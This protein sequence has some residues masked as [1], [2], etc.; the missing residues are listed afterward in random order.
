[1]KKSKAVVAL[2]NCGGKKDIVKRMEDL[3]TFDD[4]V[5]LAEELGSYC[6]SE[7]QTKGISQ[8]QV[9]DTDEDSEPYDSE[10]MREAEGDGS[11]EGQ[12][13]KES[14]EEKEEDSNKGSASGDDEEDKKEE[15]KY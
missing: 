14:E 1:M 8:L 12:K 5:K 6:K 2:F 13:E 7:M 9:G 4:V 15:D 10:D 3:E 11:S